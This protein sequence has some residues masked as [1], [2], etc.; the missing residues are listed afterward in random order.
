MRMNNIGKVKQIVEEATGLDITHFYDD[1]VFVEHSPFII[2]F[3]ESDPDNFFCYFSMD[4]GA[5]ERVS[6]F[7]NISEAAFRNGMKCSDT[8]RFEM[9]QVDGKEELEIKFYE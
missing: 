9:S 5:D 6:I 4:C 8:G 7:K 1:I 3:D 2:V